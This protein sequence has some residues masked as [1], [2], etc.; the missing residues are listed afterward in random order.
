MSKLGYSMTSLVYCC[1]AV[2]VGDMRIGVKYGEEIDKKLIDKL[3][4]ASEQRSIHIYFVQEALQDD[5]DNLTGEFE[6][7]YECQEFLDLCLADPRTIDLGTYINPNSGN[8]IH[9][10]VIKGNLP[11]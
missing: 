9:G 5:Y 4:S 6:E 3:L 10:V 8:R 11:K 7:E 1:G 2:E